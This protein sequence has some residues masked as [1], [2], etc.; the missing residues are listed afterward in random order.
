MPAEIG[1]PSTAN[2]TARRACCAGP[3]KGN[4]QA[5]V[6]FWMPR[7][8][9]C[10][11]R[12]KAAPG[13]QFFRGGKLPGNIAQH[14]R[15]HTQRASSTSSRRLRPLGGGLSNHRP[16]FCRPAATAK[17]RRPIELFLGQPRSKGWQNR[18]WA[19][20]AASKATPASWCPSSCSKKAV[21]YKPRFDF[22][23][24]AVAVVDH[25]QAEF[26][27]ALAEAMRTSAMSHRSPEFA[28]HHRLQAQP[29]HYALRPAAW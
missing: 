27:A 25:W 29:R 5:V 17:G 8:A 13:R 16:A 23:K 1:S 11:T 21:D 9:S 6:G 4:L 14:L 15:Q 26:N 10:A 3:S 18:P 24:K 2:E 19:S 20:G 22:R 12:S 7:R 28:A